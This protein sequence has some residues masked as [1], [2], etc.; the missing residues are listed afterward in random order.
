M[1]A[2]ATSSIAARAPAPPL[3]S[4][5]FNQGV[6]DMLANIKIRTLIISVLSLLTLVVAGIGAFGLLSLIHI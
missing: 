4:F 1:P 2:L 6:H 5:G 3:D